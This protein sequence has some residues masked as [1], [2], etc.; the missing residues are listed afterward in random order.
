MNVLGG[1]ATP[2][3]LVDTPY[4]ENRIFKSKN[5]SCVL[6]SLP[7]VQQGIH[8]QVPK[9]VL[10]LAKADLKGE[11]SVEIRTLPGEIIGSVRADM[12]G[13]MFDIL[14]AATRMHDMVHPQYDLSFMQFCIGET[15]VHPNSWTTRADSFFNQPVHVQRANNLVEEQKRRNQELAKQHKELTEK[16][17]ALKKD[18][19]EQERLLSMKKKNERSRC[20]TDSKENEADCSKGCTKKTSCKESGSEEAKCKVTC[21]QWHSNCRQKGTVCN[22]CLCRV[23]S[24]RGSPRKSCTLVLSV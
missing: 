9:R 11:S 18:A 14:E 13:Q 8:E 5:G 20:G 10:I 2:V 7:E 6:L 21:M 24:S 19:K 12:S 15:Y 16:E 4:Q 3:T 23:A 17:K 22:T 1:S